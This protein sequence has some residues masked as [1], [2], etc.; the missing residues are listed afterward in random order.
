M[1]LKMGGNPAFNPGMLYKN[2]ITVP[3]RVLL[4][5]AKMLQEELSTTLTSHVNPQLTATTPTVNTST[6]QKRIEAA[7]SGSGANVFDSL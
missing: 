6:L 5:S 1:L 2:C 3:V 7:K 4:A